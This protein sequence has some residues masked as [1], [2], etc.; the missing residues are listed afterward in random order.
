MSRTCVTL[1]V[2]A[3]SACNCNPSCPTGSGTGTL[4]VN[5]SGLPAGAHVAQFGIDVG[6]D[7]GHAS[8][9]WPAGPLS[10]TPELVVVP[11]E[12]V[13]SSGPLVRTVYSAHDFDVAG[14]TCVREGMSTTLSIAYSPVPSSGKLW[15]TSGNSSSPLLSYV[16]PQLHDGGTVMP[17]ATF[18]GPAGK[19]LAFDRAG[20]LWALGPTVADAMLNR[21]AAGTLGSGGAL[22]PD[23]KVNI[24][25]L[26]CL[27][28]VSALALV[29]D[30]GAWL[31]SPCQH[32]V[33]HLTQAQL[34]AAG[35][36][37]PAVTL[38]GLMAPKG[39]AFDSAGAL[40]VAD[41]DANRLLRY[42][43]AHLGASTSSPD[44]TLEV[45]QNSATLT[46]DFIAFHDDTLWGVSGTGNVVFSLSGAQL[47]GTGMQMATPGVSISIDVAALPENIAF[48]ELGGLWFAYRMGELA[49]LDPSQLTASSGPGAPTIPATVLKSS[50]IGN[51]QNVAFYAAPPSSGLSAAP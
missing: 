7:G 27:P 35:D 48:D 22:T 21:F 9:S 46:A 42:D 28:A 30:G 24:A 49:R 31:S 44:L 32:Q 6:A 1:A 17:A 3:L 15:V 45:R 11:S 12:P 20:N 25:G 19:D 2:L 41:T 50:A 5:V 26:T 14:G 13:S 39:L 10:L 23:R 38:S 43:A 47:T 16:E 8:V 33:M 36:A 40:W 37:T 18:S 29:P 4:E 51:A 34:D